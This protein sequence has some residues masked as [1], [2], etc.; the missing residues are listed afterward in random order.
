MNYNS[1]TTIMSDVGNGEDYS[2]VWPWAIW[3][4]SVCS[5]QF[6]CEPK[7][8]KKKNQFSVRKLDLTKGSQFS[9]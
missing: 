1:C 9:D 4:L 7:T 8:L 2:S 6:F 3:E 5:S